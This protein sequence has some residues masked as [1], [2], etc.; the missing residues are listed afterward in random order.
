MACQNITPKSRKIC[1]AKLNKRIQLQRN[2]LISKGFDDPDYDNVLTTF[3]TVWSAIETT[4][5][6]ESFNNLLFTKNTGL[7]TPI[8]HKFYIRFNPNLKILEPSAVSSETVVEFN[9]EKYNIANVENIDE[10]DEYQ[11]LFCT[12]RGLFV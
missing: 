12:K 2:T 6:W 1:L 7:Q 4:K 3:A 8:T 11:I 5:G 9:S 10:K